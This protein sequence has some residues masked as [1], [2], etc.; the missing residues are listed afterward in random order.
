M[1]KPLSNLIYEPFKQF[2]MTRLPFCLDTLRINVLKSRAL[3]QSET[4]PP[5]KFELFGSI[6]M[7]FKWI[8]QK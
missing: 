3:G 1:S 2:F 6:P 5:P 7:A 8:N 4:F